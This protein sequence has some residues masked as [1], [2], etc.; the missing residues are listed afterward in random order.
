ML[1]ERK[2]QGRLIRAECPEAYARMAAN[3]LDAFENFARSRGSLGPGSQLRFGWSVLRLMED[4][5]AL[6]VAEPDFARWAEGQWLPTIET[7]LR[8]LATQTALLHRLGVTGEDA[9]C[10][11]WLVAASGA[12]AQ[13]KVFLRRATSV[14]AEDSGWLLGAIDD[15]E[16]LAREDNLEAV[17]LASLVTR[18]PALLQTMV[19]PRGFITI[20]SGDSLEQVLDSAGR[21]LLGEGATQ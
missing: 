3:V 8:I 20:Y 17:L 1:V 13:A 12:L 7:T 15:P 10:D 2:I 21:T 14:S 18:R 5:P 19:L 4:G 16:A 6:R 11:Q 9:F